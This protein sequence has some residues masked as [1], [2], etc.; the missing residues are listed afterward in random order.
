[1]NKITLRTFIRKMYNEI[2]D[3]DIDEITTTGDIDGYSTPFAFKDDGNDKKRK[4]KFKSSVKEDI[5]REDTKNVNKL[6]RFE[7]ARIIRDIWIKR[8]SWA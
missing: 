3:E 6:I 2:Q 7:V 8:T 4:R 1:M 5:T